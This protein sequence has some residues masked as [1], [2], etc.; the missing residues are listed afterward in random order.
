MNVVV[1]PQAIETVSSWE[2]VCRES[3]AKLLN[4]LSYEEVIAPEAQ[5]GDRFVLKLQSCAV[6]SF[7]A[8]LGAWD[9][10]LV[11]PESIQRKPEAEAFPSPLQFVVDARAEMAMKPDTEA[12]FLRELS[13]TLRQD[14][15]LLEKNHRVQGEDLVNAPSH[16]RHALL[17]G[18]PKAV[19][20]KGRLGW[21]MDDVRRFSPEHRQDF[22]IVWLAADRTQ[23]RIGDSSGVDERAFLSQCL[24][25]EEEQR[26]FAALEAQGLSLTTHTLVPAHPW[27]WD[28]V[29]Q[30]A[31]VGELMERRLV[32]L[33]AFGGRYVAGPSLRT[34]TS[35]DRPGSPDIKLALM[36]LNT[37]AWRG[38]PGQYIALGS[39]ISDWLEGLVAGDE[40]LAANVTILREQRGIW[41]RHP[42]YDQVPNTPYQHL[43]TLGAI[44]RE[45]AKSRIS[46]KQDACLYAALLHV[47]GDGV[48]LAVHH[49]NRA[50]MPISEWLSELFQTTVVPLYHFLA[51]YGVGFIAHGQNITVVLEDHR[52][53]GLAIKDLQG[54]VD[55]VNQTFAEH[56]GLPDEIRSILPNKPPEYIVHDI[57]TAHFVTVL[58]F[59]SERLDAAG[60]ITEGDFYGLLSRTLKT[61]MSEHPELAERF[62][63]FEL[64]H[65]TLPRV[66]INKVRFEIGYGDAAERPLPALGTD[67]RNPLVH[68]AEDNL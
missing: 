43:E 10:L 33:G 51:K 24:G 52:P 42:I 14:L 3:L 64:F 23:C 59:F 45:N 49:A 37:S 39:A 17:E 38:I 5:G 9:N 29:L 40:L 57:Q 65:P 54:D 36:I 21:G 27:Q 12:T 48:P 41:Y 58:R 47:A 1:A 26:L 60:A 53:A 31:Y 50:G 15:V 22:E 28:H 13:N 56:S 68:F 35:I 34:L 2:T 19:A 46:T 30:Q 18:H 62:R 20:N 55:I 8:K 61:Y 11:H 4:E 7:A 63:T 6:Y 25:K 16:V 66:C 67:L 32:F 44:W